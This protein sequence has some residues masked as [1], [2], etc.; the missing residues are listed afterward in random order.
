MS[1][2]NFSWLS[3]VSNT[4]DASASWLEPVLTLSHWEPNIAAFITFILE[5]HWHWELS[6]SIR[7]EV[8]KILKESVDLLVLIVDEVVFMVK[9]IIERSIMSLKIVCSSW[10]IMVN[11]W[12]IEMVIGY[13]TNWAMGME[14]MRSSWLIVVNDSF[15]EMIIMHLSHLS[16]VS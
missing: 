8:R 9:I 12:R 16:A 14:V 6:L 4:L 7:E 1:V 5:V 11:D 3:S 2:S 10:L 13:F 15:I